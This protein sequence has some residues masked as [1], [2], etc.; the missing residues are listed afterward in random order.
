MHLARTTVDLE[1]A[2]GSIK[3]I[4]QFVHIACTYHPADLAALPTL[5]ILPDPVQKARNVLSTLPA[6]SVDK[7][8]GGNAAAFYGI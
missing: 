1:C 6:A 5:C 4:G 2:E 3:R 7:I 8:L